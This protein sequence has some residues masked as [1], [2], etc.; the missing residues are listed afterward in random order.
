MTEHNLHPGHRSSTPPG[1]QAS[2]L[3]GHGLRPSRPPS[4]VTVTRTGCAAENPV[5]RPHLPRRKE[6]TRDPGVA[7]GRG[8]PTCRDWTTNTL[9]R[10]D[11]ARPTKLSQ[12]G[13]AER[14]P[15]P[16][17][18]RGNLIKNGKIPALGEAVGLAT[19][20]SCKGKEKVDRGRARQ[21]AAF[22]HAKVGQRH[23]AGSALALARER[24]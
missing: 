7:P 15:E 17:P 12:T 13:Q 16:A 10:P 11:L 20:G 23:L 6:G 8:P 18:E 22:S 21:T 9:E 5:S 2:H 24:G 4:V 1:H 19:Q 14:A 3:G